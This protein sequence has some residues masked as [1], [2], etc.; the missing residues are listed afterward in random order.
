MLMGG[1]APDDPRRMRLSEVKPLNMTW[2]QPWSQRAATTK[3]GILL[4][5]EVLPA[6]SL[7]V[8]PPA[9]WLP[10]LPLMP[11]SELPEPVVFAPA[12]I[13]RV[14]GCSMSAATEMPPGPA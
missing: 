10:M 7:A 4:L 14:S 1:V 11:W 9:V 2:P 6:N 5:A 12:E 8:A 3:F 13:Q